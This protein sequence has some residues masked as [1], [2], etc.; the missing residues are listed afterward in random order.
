M[1][2]NVV[3]YSFLALAVCLMLSWLYIRLDTSQQSGNHFNVKN[4]GA[5]GD[6]LTDDTGA[7]QAAINKAVSIGGG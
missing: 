5:R 3:L 7:I 2:K 1:K 4:F 6:N